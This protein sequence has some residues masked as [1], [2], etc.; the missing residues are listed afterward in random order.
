MLRKAA[1]RGIALPAVLS[2]RL[3]L[4]RGGFIQRRLLFLVPQ[5]VAVSIITFLLVR[6][7]PGNPALLLLGPLSRPEQVAALEEKLG[8]HDP[9]PNQYFKYIGRIFQGDFG[10][11]HFTSQP[12]A[13]DIRERLPRTVELITLALALSLVIMVPLGVRAAAPK[14]AGRGGLIDRAI[15]RVITFYGLLAGSLADFWLALILIFIFFTK[16][17]WAPEPLG[18]LGLGAEPDRVTGFLTIDSIIAGDGTALRSYLSHLGLPLATL[19]FV[20]GGPILKATM[21]AIR[22]IQESPYMENAQAMGLKLGTRRRYAFRNALPPVITMVGVV[23][24][25]LLGGAVLVET[26]FGLNGFGKYGVD[27]VV[28]ADYAPVQSFVLVAAVF[29]MAVYLIVDLL[30]AWSDPR[31]RL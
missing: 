17:G 25:F 30:H 15:G 9:L 7:L 22:E 21:S 31:V 14:Q 29:V 6:L 12:V 13:K 28:N 5:L 2:F 10:N 18:A 19:V 27:A 8:L 23:Y 20:Y 4:P 24:G 3:P 26:V 1:L 16:L 11:S